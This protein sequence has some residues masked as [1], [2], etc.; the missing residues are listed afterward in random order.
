MPSKL[1]VVV[2]TDLDMGR[3]KVAAQV[4]HAAVTATLQALGTSALRAWLADGQ[5]K[6]V[7]RVPDEAA[8]AEVADA[9]GVAGLP[10]TVIRDAGRT[11]VAPG[12]P[13]C[14]AVGPA[15]VEAIDPVTGGLRML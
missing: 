13:T 9:A 15:P 7:L 14:L 1:V 10:T 3:G 6:V 8:L 11:Q 12:T 5:P 4:A 2:R